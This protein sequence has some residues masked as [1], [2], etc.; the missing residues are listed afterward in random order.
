MGKQGME[1]E[2]EERMQGEGWAF[3]ESKCKRGQ[4][5]RGGL[6]RPCWPQ[7]RPTAK[8]YLDRVGEVA[9]SSRNRNASL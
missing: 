1:V 3:L 4:G 2:K 9:P 8:V 6:P 5:S 7:R